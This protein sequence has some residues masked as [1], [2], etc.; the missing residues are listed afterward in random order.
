M[1]VRFGSGSGLSRK[2]T[3]FS[4]NRDSAQAQG[5]VAW[6]PFSQGKLAAE[7][8]MSNKNNGVLTNGCSVV[9]SVGGLNG[10]CSQY[11][12]GDDFVELGSIADGNP[13]MLNGSALTI[14][15]WVNKTSGGDIYQ[16]IVDKSSAGNGT[17]GYG[18]W[19]HAQRIGYSVSGNSTRTDSSTSLPSYSV[20]HHV[21]GAADASGNINIYVNAILEADTYYGG[22]SAAAPP[23]ATANMRIGSWNHSTGREWGGSLDDV[24]IYNRQLTASEVWNLFDP[25]SRFDLYW[26]RHRVY[27]L[28]PKEAVSSSG[29]AMNH[30]L[31][32]LGAYA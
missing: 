27:S 16:R 30:H 29:G 11:D 23:D 9:A 18:M 21:V 25:T 15:A 13:L 4:I 10:V 14:S 26:T 8:S 12:G 5:L 22:G 32:Q 1:V 7:S 17:N 31:Q 3:E 24:R 28:A 2:P 19:I 20:W 6:W